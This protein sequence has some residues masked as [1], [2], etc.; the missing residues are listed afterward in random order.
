MI[1]RDIILFAI[2]VQQ[3]CCRVSSQTPSK[4]RHVKCGL[5]LNNTADEMFEVSN[6]PM[7]DTGDRIMNGEEVIPDEFPW[8]VS[9]QALLSSK[10]NEGTW[11]HQCGGSVVTPNLIVTAAHCDKIFDIRANLA[12]FRVVAGCHDLRDADDCQV[13]EFYVD[14]FFRHEKYSHKRKT[15]DIAIL[16]L[17]KSLTFTHEYRHAV[18]PVCLPHRSDVL[19]QGMA[20]VGGYG[21]SK[22]FEATKVMDPVMQVVDLNILSA[23]DCEKTHLRKNSRGQ[24]VDLGF[25]PKRQMCAGFKKGIKDTC[26]GDS[27]G[28]LMVSVHHQVIIIGIVSFGPEDECGVE[29]KPGIYTKVAFFLDWIVDKVRKHSKAAI[30]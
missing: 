12:R 2:T 11:R 28:P 1:L 22:N 27:G 14:D 20:A 8:I 18:G 21:A 23:I 24:T 25:D 3:Y 6:Y 5:Q 4:L 19:Y 26:Q 30:K 7:K 9:L 17:R 15:N 16:R 13:V 10:S 29:D